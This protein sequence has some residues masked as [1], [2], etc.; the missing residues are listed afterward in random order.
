MQR[1]PWTPLSFLSK[2]PKQKAKKIFGFVRQFL[3]KFGIRVYQR[4]ITINYKQ[5]HIDK[6]KKDF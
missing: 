1:D 3:Q 4:L 6:I 5:I 2:S